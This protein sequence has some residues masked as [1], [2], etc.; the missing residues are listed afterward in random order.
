MNDVLLISYSPTWKNNL[1]AQRNLVYSIQ[2]RE[3]TKNSIVILVRPRS[4]NLPEKHVLVNGQP[5]AGLN[6]LSFSSSL[7]LF[8]IFEQ[9]TH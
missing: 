8:H 3:P 1:L 2:Q 5:T 4:L 9:S 6:S 7:I